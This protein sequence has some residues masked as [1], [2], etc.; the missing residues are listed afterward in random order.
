MRAHAILLAVL[1]TSGLFSGCTDPDQGE[2]LLQPQEAV[3]APVQVNATTGGSEFA[4]PQ[5]VV[6]RWWD[7]EVQLDNGYGFLTDLSGKLIVGSSNATGFRVGSD[8]AGI[9]TFDRYFDH[10]HIGDFDAGLNASV[11]G[12]KVQL[13]AW[14][15]SP[16]K[17]WVAQYP[18]Y[19]D[20]H[21]VVAYNATLTVG[22]FDETPATERLRIQG[23]LENG[24]TLDY[25]YSAATGWMTYFRMINK[26]TG[27]VAL[28]IDFIKTGLDHRGAV[29]HVTSRNLYTRVAISPPLDPSIAGVPPIERVEIAAG[30][31]WVE[32]IA[33]LFV[34]PM[35]GAG[36]GVAS[37]S[38][39]RPD[40]KVDRQTFNH[41]GETFGA[42][43]TRIPVRGATAGTWTITVQASGT[44]GSIV[45]LNGFNDE[46]VEIG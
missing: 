41:A 6:G 26:T 39:Q 46:V 12:T 33:F 18:L 31:D 22:T 25:D 16:G 9:G 29:H 40:M 15:L 23:E 11:Q 13:F 45:W 34:Y 37:Y 5:W 35:M 21:A 36:G 38:I 17:T 7:V 8:G 32:E 1:L 28:S 27:R 10:F 2:D 20:V 24:N 4:R 43:F 14:P 3:F 42:N 30:N 44:A 19:D